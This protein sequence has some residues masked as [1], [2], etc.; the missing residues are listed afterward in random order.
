VAQDIATAMAEIV[1]RQAVLSI[2][3]PTAASVQKAWDYF[4][5]DAVGVPDDYTFMNSW[6]LTGTE[7]SAGL[8]YEKY[9]VH[10]QLFIRNADRDVGIKI[11]AAFH[12]AL[13]AAFGPHPTLGGKVADQQIRGGTPTLA[14][15]SRA[16]VD[17]PGLDLFMDVTIKNAMTFDNA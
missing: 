5:P 8:F 16:G 7:R 9:V 13:L 10:M 2:A 14:N 1:A 11:A 6:S 4:P 12:A 3:S 17:Y 15:L